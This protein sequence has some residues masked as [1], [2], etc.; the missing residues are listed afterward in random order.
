MSSHPRSGTTRSAGLAVLTALVCASLLA[1]PRYSWPA[2]K[3]QVRIERDV[4]LKMR[5][6]VRLATDLYMPV[7]KGAKLPA[8]LIRTPYNKAPFR[9]GDSDAHGLA[10]QGYVVA[11]QDLRGKYLSEGDY[12]EFAGDATDGYD[13]TDWLSRQPWSNGKVGTY[14]CSYLGDVQILQA[15]QRH[16][17]LKAMIP[18]AAGASVGSA[19]GRYYYFGSRKAGTWELASGLGWYANAGSKVRGK[20]AQNIPDSTLRKFWATLPLLGMVERAGGP[21]TDWDDLVSRELNDPWW[22]RFGSLKD[23]DRFNVPALHI[24]SWYDYGVAEVLLEFNLFRS[25]AESS[26]AGDNQFAIIS[27]GNHC[28]SESLGEH[29]VIGE[30]EMGDARFEFYPLYLKWFDHWLKGADNGVTARPKL[31]LYIMGRNEWRAEQEWP[32]A[33]TAYTRYY[34]HSDG[35]AD[36][37]LGTGTLSTAVPGTEPSDGYTYDPADPVPSRGGP[38]C[39]TGDSE[40]EGSYDQSKIE[41]RPDVLVYTTPV[42]KNGIEVT[43]PLQAVLYVSSSARDTDFTAKL[44]D[45]YPDGAAYNVQEGILRSRYREGFTRKVWMEPDKV[46]ELMVDLEV[47]ANYFGPGHRIRVEISSSNFPRFDRNLNTGGNNYDETKWLAAQN[48]IHHSATHASYL[49]LPVIP[50]GKPGRAA[51]TQPGL[52]SVARSGGPAR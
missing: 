2:P 41:M 30:R 35:H 46:Y 32:L 52:P 15:P 25:N 50:A 42:L 7:G 48:R 44:V 26:V 18:R 51:A 5:D 13:T 9:G 47:T 28:Q 3:S 36:T 37:R 33:R 34:L 22:D 31:M 43:G 49:L 39:C 4:M 16:P 1:E 8:I 45:V 19:G 40:A 27:P 20:P 6:G 23:D 11:V 21:P 24:D 17:N 12:S 38:V 10:G 29:T 14:G